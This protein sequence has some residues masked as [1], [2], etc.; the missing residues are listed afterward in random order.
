MVIYS[1]RAHSLLGNRALC[2]AIWEWII[3][4]I[5]PKQEGFWQLHVYMWILQNFRRNY[6]QLIWDFIS[7]HLWKEKVQRFQAIRSVGVGAPGSQLFFDAFCLIHTATFQAK[8][9]WNTKG[10]TR[11]LFVL[12]LFRKNNPP[13]E[14]PTKQV[15]FKRNIVGKE[16]LAMRGIWKPL[17][18]DWIRRMGE[19]YFFGK[20]FESEEAQ[21][22][23]GKLDW[24]WKTGATQ[25][26][27]VYESIAPLF[28]RLCLQLLSMAIS[29]PSS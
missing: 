15:E 7:K 27:E 8:M 24:L 4:W 10:L 22:G 21:Q 25:W 9:T 26:K 5:F 6:W 29:M 20:S 1:Q 19:I 13:A 28:T 12:C 16:A 17:H 14:S 3:W 11:P 18:K 23:K 2:K